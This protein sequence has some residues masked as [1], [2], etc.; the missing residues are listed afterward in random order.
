MSKLPIVLPARNSANGT[1][2]LQNGSRPWW[3][4]G[5]SKLW[6]G[7]SGRNWRAAF[8]FIGRSAEARNQGAAQVLQAHNDPLLSGFCAA[9]LL[10]RDQRIPIVGSSIKSR[11]IAALLGQQTLCAISPNCKPT[12]EVTKLVMET[13]APTQRYSG[14]EI[15]K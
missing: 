3:S 13:S 10:R 4:D 7:A 14:H 11:A 2:G 1:G 6:I 12:C 5:R 8:H 15:R 9:R